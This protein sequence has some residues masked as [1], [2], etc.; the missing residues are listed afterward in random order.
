MPLTER[1]L[2][3]NEIRTWL[4]ATVVR[5]GSAKLIVLVLDLAPAG[6][7]MSPDAARALRATKELL[8]LWNNPPSSLL[9][10]KHPLQDLFKV[11]YD[12]VSLIPWPSLP[13]KHPPSPSLPP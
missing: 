7:L 1:I 11:L 5:G 10:A 12:Q 3:P 13:L 9:N 4:E 2:Y 8:N 6:V